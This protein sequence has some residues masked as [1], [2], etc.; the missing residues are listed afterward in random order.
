MRVNIGYGCDL[1]DVQEEISSFLERVSLKL[2]EAAANV[3][4]TSTAMVLE[5]YDP[6]E[7]L[8]GIHNVRVALNKLDLRLED[9]STIIV[10][11]ENAKAK[12]AAGEDLVMMPEDP[13]AAAPLQVVEPEE[14]SS[15]VKGPKTKKAKRGRKKKGSN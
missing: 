2:N 5:N 4:K 3:G 9:A 11:L 8:L 6:Q 14:E 13:E 7:V 15:R 12:I 10:G 1:E